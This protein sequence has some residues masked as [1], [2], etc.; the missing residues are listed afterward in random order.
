MTTVN[1]IF[2]FLC[3]LAPVE[4]AMDYDNCGFLV[5]DLGSPVEKVLL[6]LDIT[7]QVV[8]LAKELGAELIVSHHPVIFHP[9]KR[10]EAGSAPYM[11]A[12][13]GISAVCMHTNLDR[14]D[15][16][17]VNICLARAAGLKN[18]ELD[19]ENCIAYGEVEE[20]SAADFAAAVKNA[21][22]CCG[23][24]YTDSGAAVRRV[25]V[26]G[27][28]GGGNIFLITGKADAFVVG[29][30]RHHELLY[31]AE[32]GISVIDAG[33][34]KTEEIVLPALLSRLSERFKEVSFTVNSGDNDCILY[35]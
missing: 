4:T 8:T 6:A 25:A 11:L 24:R 5:G 1:D 7:P 34:R 17:G 35:L 9:L 26:S 19:A 15:E 32:K 3:T 21:L 12:Q 22:G 23:V 20:T 16:C 10:L 14:A 29:E 18:I 13:S 27:G 28:A 2:S 33:H 31:A 30:I